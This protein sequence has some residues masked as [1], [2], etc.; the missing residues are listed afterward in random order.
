MVFSPFEL[1]QLDNH[2]DV[3]SQ[4][5]ESSFHI[6]ENLQSTWREEEVSDISDWQL[7][8][9]VLKKL[10]STLQD[11]RWVKKNRNIPE[12]LLTFANLYF[13]LDFTCNFLE[14]F[15]EHYS[16]SEE[17]SMTREEG[18]SQLSFLVICLLQSI[19][20]MH[21]LSPQ[22]DTQVRTLLALSLSTH[23]RWTSEH[24]QLLLKACAVPCTPNAIFKVILLLLDAGV[25]PNSL[26]NDGRSALH[27]LAINECALA[28]WR[29]RIDWGN[30]RAMLFTSVVKTFMKSGFRSNLIDSFGRT[31]LDVFDVV[32]EINQCIHPDYAFMRVL[33]DFKN[34]LKCPMDC[35]AKVVCS[36]SCLCA[37]VIQKRH[38]PC[39][40]LPYRLQGLVRLH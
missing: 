34:S 4:N 26:D 12:T 21:S 39:L 6:I 36:L 2:N 40:M 37:K 13:C 14:T 17:S 29:D 27:L 20:E 15:Y 28:P 8:F 35:S 7:V 38:I 30:R 32:L 24:P 33:R 1:N 11:R 10:H 31:A 9:E 22:E 16:P 23:N 18:V 25:D 3:L 5:F 19:Y